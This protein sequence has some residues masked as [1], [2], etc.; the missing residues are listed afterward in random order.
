MPER[1]GLE[2]V[3]L[4]ATSDILAYVMILHD[5]AGNFLFFGC[6]FDFIWSE[7]VNVCIVNQSSCLTTAVDREWSAFLK[8]RAP[9]DDTEHFIRISRFSFFVV[10]SART[11]LLLY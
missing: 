4:S 7:R 9:K 2:A 6:L 3:F 5:D 8:E 11:G 10:L 1:C